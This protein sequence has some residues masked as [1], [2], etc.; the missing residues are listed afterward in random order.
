MNSAGHSPMTG[1]VIKA[2]SVAVG[3]H[4]PDSLYRQ[5]VQLVHRLG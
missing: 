3:P 5:S 1:G 2:M 4:R